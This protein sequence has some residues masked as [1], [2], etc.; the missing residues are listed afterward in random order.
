MLPSRDRGKVKSSAT[1]EYHVV[2]RSLIEEKSLISASDLI[3][4]GLK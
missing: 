4:A 2:C 1:N 3:D